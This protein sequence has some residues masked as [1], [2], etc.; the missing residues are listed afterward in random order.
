MFLERR[1]NFITN[2]RIIALSTVRFRT[3]RIPTL[4][5]ATVASSLILDILRNI[6]YI[7]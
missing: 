2:Y 7:L 6:Y 1:I 3:D 5:I 4:G